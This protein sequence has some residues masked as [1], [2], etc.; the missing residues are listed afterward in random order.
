MGTYFLRGRLEEGPAAG[1]ELTQEAIHAPLSIGVVVFNFLATRVLLR[2][3]MQGVGGCKCVF[4]FMCSC[5]NVCTYVQ[6]CVCVC[7]CSSIS[8][9]VNE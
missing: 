9:G 5:V 8:V 6:A 4:V 7:I 2:S 1:L 3:V